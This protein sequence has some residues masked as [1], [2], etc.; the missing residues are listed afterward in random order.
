VPARSFLVA[1]LPWAAVAGA[2][3]G[4]SGGAGAP[5]GSDAALATGSIGD[6]APNDALIL[7]IGDGF[8]GGETGIFDCALAASDNCWK[9][10][11]AAAAGCLP[12]S[13]ET[14][15]LSAD[16]LTCTY[17]TG[18]VVAFASPLVLGPAATVSTFSVTTGGRQCLHYLLASN[19]TTLTTSAGSVT[20][21]VSPDSQTVTLACPDGATYVGTFAT[22]NTCEAGT[23][24][25]YDDGEGVTRMG[26]AA[27]SGHF[28]LSLENTDSNSSNGLLV[29]DCASPGD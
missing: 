7:A 10:T 19:G 18:T 24:P 13:S 14:G 25:G 1:L 11:V 28:T 6:S 4:G 21:L 22:L 5:A 8:S 23:I 20:L 12:A 27:Y 17:P 29:F 2:A 16:G 26:D 15:T 3:C 9:T